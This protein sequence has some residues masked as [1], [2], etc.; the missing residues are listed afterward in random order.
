[1]NAANQLKKHKAIVTAIGLLIFSLSCVM[2]NVL[3]WNV[4]E[5]LTLTWA[6]LIIAGSL[7]FLIDYRR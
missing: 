5:W 3:K 1:M 7:L 2:T 6:G 4:P